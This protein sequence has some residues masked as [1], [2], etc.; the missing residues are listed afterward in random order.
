MLERASALFHPFS[1]AFAP[2]GF[3]WTLFFRHAA[4]EAEEVAHAA[5]SVCTERGFTDMLAW[6]KCFLGWALIEQGKL[7]DGIAKLSEGIAV[8]DSIRNLISKSLF[9]GALADGYKKAGDAKRALELLDEAVDWANQTGERFYKCE[10][11]RIRG[12]VLLMGNGPNAPAA[13]N[14]FRRL[15][16]LLACE[17]PKAGNCAQR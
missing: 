8:L 6:A 5:I 7:T 13:D 15:S 3:E 9:L 1:R 2:V 11:H 12:E 10:L 4:R 16:S 14:C 17:A